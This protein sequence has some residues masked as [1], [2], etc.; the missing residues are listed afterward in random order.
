MHKKCIL[1]LLL[2]SLFCQCHNGNP[3]NFKTSLP[4]QENP[5]GK[6]GKA[7]TVRDIKVNNNQIAKGPVINITD[8]V[9]EKELLLTIKDSAA[10]LERLAIK[11]HYIYDSLMPLQ[12]MKFNLKQT[13]PPLAFYKDQVAPYFFEAAIPVNEKVSLKNSKFYYKIQESTPAI[14]AHFFGP[15]DLLN[16]GYGSLQEYIDN[17]KLARRGSSFEIY[18][19][20][21]AAGK[22]DIINPYRV[23][24]DIVMPVR[25][26]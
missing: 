13:G 3:E 20:P 24:T 2:V 17:Q 22:K 19:P 9:I 1:Y 25:K 6:V 10:N 18:F 23:Q 11:L 15:K 7:D 16:I 5:Y 14:V 21:Q 8:T 12:L 26:Q 4:A